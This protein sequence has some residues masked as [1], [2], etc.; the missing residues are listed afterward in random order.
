MRAVRTLNTLNKNDK[1]LRKSLSR[2]ATGT[3][4][5]S[6]EDDASAY[7]ISE[8]MRV[9]LRALEQ[10]NQ[11]T[12]ND[13]S[14]MRTA[15]GVVANT[16]E[17][18][19]SL[20]EKAINAA[21]DSNNDD[22]RATL[23]KEIDQLID[24]VDDNAHITFN[25]KYMLTGLSSN[26]IHGTSNSNTWSRTIL[27]NQSL[28]TDTVLGQNMTTLKKSCRRFARNSIKRHISS[29]VGNQRQRHGEHRKSFA[30]GKY[31]TAF[32]GRRVSQSPNRPKLCRGGRANRLGSLRTKIIRNGS[33]RK[34]FFKS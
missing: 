1:K 15:E 13:S 17:I 16:V 10:A 9:R 23:Q 11:N 14:L 22:D 5:T 26:A 34:R 19:K 3:K 29:F 20:K 28:A 21:N 24:Q 33:G 27:L 25:G 12:Q 31:R 30:L 2:V 6:A 18:L 4:I 7:G 32:V 8:R